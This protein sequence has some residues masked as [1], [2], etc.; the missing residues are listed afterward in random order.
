MANFKAVTYTGNGTSQGITGVGFQ[1]DLV[2]IKRRDNTGDWYAFDSTRGATKYFLINTNAL[3]ATDAQTLTSFDSDGF[4]VGNAA[5]V[6]AN[7]GT[8]VAFCFKKAS[9][10]FDIVSYTG[11]GSGRTINHALGATPEFMLTKRLTGATSAAAIYHVGA[12]GGSSPEGQLVNPTT[13]SAPSSSASVWNNTAPTSSVFSVGANANSNNNT[14]AYIIYIWGSDSSSSGKV[15]SGFF[16]A[17]GSGTATLSG[18]SQQPT[19]LF[20]KRSNGS[21]EFRVFD[22]VRGFAAGNDKKLTLQS[23]VAEGTTTNYGAFTSDGATLQGLATATNDYL[24]TFFS[25]AGGT[26]F[27]DTISEGL[28][29]SDSYA[30]A[31]TANPSL[32]ETVT[33]GESVAAGNVMGATLTE[34]ATSGDSVSAA[35]TANAPLTESG[36]PG[37]NNAVTLTANPSL[38]ES[39]IPGDSNAAAATFGVTIT[40]DCTPGD[41]ITGGLLF[42]LDITESATP[43]DQVDAQATFEAPRSEALTAGDSLDVTLTANTSISEVLTA[44][45]SYAAA[46][47]LNAAYQENATLL[48]SLAAA[49][50][51]NASI[52][53]TATPGDSY[54]GAVIFNTALVEE[55]IG[56]EAFSAMLTANPSLLEAVI[57]SD[58]MAATAIFNELY[59]ETLTATDD[60]AAEDAGQF[61]LDPRH[62]SERPGGERVNAHDMLARISAHPGTARLRKTTAGVRISV[63]PGK[64]RST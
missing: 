38:S 41:S 3:E 29:A 54:S 16:T 17:S 35:L 59:Q 13:S 11:N 27:N 53:E 57:C 55:I 7:T 62:I 28:T 24:Y 34:A 14:N 61:I 23:N 60:Y 12:N 58:D 56:A 32:T 45:D 63:H 18:M 19:W 25:N 64:G 39:A 43:G 37:D 50:T 44:L 10:F 20:Y 49:L 51:A 8:Y 5:G 1:P 2:I 40:E 26:I 21:E 47:T 31:L 33:A 36:T 42:T 30:A 22:D 9:G 4:S 15:R 48:D 46:A 52:T 6:N